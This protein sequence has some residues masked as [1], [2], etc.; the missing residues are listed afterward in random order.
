MQSHQR[1]F[2]LIELMVVVFIIAMVAAGV[3]QVMQPQ[4][5][6]SK[7]INQQ[8]DR[9]FAQMQFALDDALVHYRPLGIAFPH[10]GDD[11]DDGDGDYKSSYQD[12][13]GLPRQY[14]WYRY[15]G[16]DWTLTEKPLGSHNLSE[17]LIWS[18]EV[19]EVSVEE[20]LDS[21]LREEEEPIKPIVVFHPSGEVTEFD[22]V[23]ALSDKGLSD[24]PEAV[25][26]RYKI[27]L[28]DRGQLTR[29]A[30]G[31]AE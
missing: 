2:S 16:E 26:Q 14:A 13:P 1:G 8:G 20:A 19:E 22:L 25:N 18:I 12:Y 7:R 6:S 15:D 9:L 31:E 23:I 4:G 3:S 29:L 21:L 24:N 30:V 10:N 27:A 11:G 28:N 5:S 17:E